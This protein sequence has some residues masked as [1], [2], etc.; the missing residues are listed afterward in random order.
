MFR[1]SNRCEGNLSN[2]GYDEELRAERAYI[3][4]LYARLDRERDEARSATATL[5]GNRGPR[6]WSGTRTCASG[7]A[8]RSG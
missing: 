7:R 6:W 1:Q 4:G 8:R 2:Q 5:S 3:D